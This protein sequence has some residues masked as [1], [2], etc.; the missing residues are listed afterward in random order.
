MSLQNKKIKFLATTLLATTLAFSIGADDTHADQAF[1]YP[2]SGYSTHNKTLSDMGSS[3]KQTTS[4]YAT[5]TSLKYNSIKM[6]SGTGGGA[7]GMMWIVDNVNRTSKQVNTFYCKNVKGTT[8]T[9][10]GTYTVG[11]NSNTASWTETSMFANGCYTA[12]THIDDVI[13]KKSSSFSSASMESVPDIQ[14]ATN[15]VNSLKTSEENAQNQVSFKILKSSK[16]PLGFKKETFISKAK[17]S[18]TV[19]TIFSNSKNP[20]EHIRVMNSNR[21]SNLYAPQEIIN[22]NGMKAEYSQTIRPEE[23]DVLYEVNINKNG[24]NTVIIG[25]SKGNI[26][27]KSIIDFA[28]NLK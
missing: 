19:D 27:K 4:V 20:E 16:N 26:N 1:A 21:V 11:W 9:W 13:F 8:Y 7:W 6:S 28:K 24:T 23:N 5:S 14:N 17:D 25:L 18:Y 2:T 3:Y 15:K 10:P 22:I 12:T